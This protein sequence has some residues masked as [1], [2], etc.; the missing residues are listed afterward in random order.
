LHEDGKTIVMKPL[1][2]YPPMSRDL[3]LTIAKD[4]PAGMLLEEIGKTSLDIL[5]SVE[6]F[7]CYEDDKI[8]PDR[9]S[10]ALSFIFQ[11]SDKTLLASDIDKAIARI[12]DILEKN[13]G[14]TIRE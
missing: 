7:D 5:Q 2:K 13:C 11:A 12:L 6:I 4:K 3:S 1:S 8:G 9:K 10:V 14:A